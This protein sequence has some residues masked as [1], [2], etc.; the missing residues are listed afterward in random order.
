MPNMSATLKRLSGLRQLR[1]NLV[2]AFAGWWWAG[3]AWV[4]SLQEPL[5]QYFFGFLT[6]FTLVFIAS[7]S[8]RAVSNEKREV[9]EVQTAFLVGQQMG[10]FA[11]KSTKTLTTEANEPD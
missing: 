9:R 5:H 11:S 7:I 3:I 6:A 4:S 1:I 10:L 8:E 2:P